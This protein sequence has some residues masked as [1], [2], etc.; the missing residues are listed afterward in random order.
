MLALMM[1][2]VLR[3]ILVQDYSQTTPETITTHTADDLRKRGY[4]EEQIARLQEDPRHK[5]QRRD[6][7]PS[8]KRD[9]IT[10]LKRDVNFLL[11]EVSDLRRRTVNGEEGGNDPPSTDDIQR[12]LDILHMQKRRKR[13]EKMGLH[14]DYAD[15]L[16]WPVS[17]G[18]AHARDAGFR[19]GSGERHGRNHERLKAARHGH[20]EKIGEKVDANTGGLGGVDTKQQG[21]EASAGGGGESVEEDEAEERRI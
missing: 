20:F 19:E 10:A 14:T 2:F 21:G 7:G 18:D 4:S 12:E 5:T 8:M 1:L 6:L 16:D 13:E 17:D 3:N 15:G 9:E 11:R